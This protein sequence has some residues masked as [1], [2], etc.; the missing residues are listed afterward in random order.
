VFPDGSPWSTWSIGADMDDAMEKAAHMTLTA[1]C[2]QNLAATTG[3]P[4][5]CILSRTALTQSGR[6][7]WMRWAASFRFTTI[8]AGRTWPDM[9]STYFSYSM[10]LS[11][12]LR[13]SGVVLL[14]M[15]RKSRT[16]PRRSVAR[17]KRMVPC[18]SRSG[19]WRVAFATR[20]RHF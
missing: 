20:R 6:L 3:M 16:S 8:V 19:T 7:T 5:R 17:P 12:L 15:P 10:T 11:A 13:S 14:V 4:S 2:S 18:V 9:P 1:L